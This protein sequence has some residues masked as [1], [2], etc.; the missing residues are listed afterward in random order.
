MNKE[1]KTT[2]LEILAYFWD[3]AASLTRF[4]KWEILSVRGDHLSL[5][6]NNLFSTDMNFTKKK[7]VNK[8]LYYR[9]NQTYLFK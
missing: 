2:S 8:S 5:S 4:A 6:E 7:T 3:K 9:I 1:I